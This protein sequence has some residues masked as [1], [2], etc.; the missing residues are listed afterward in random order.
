MN[1]Y[2][3]SF[4]TNTEFLGATVVEGINEK[5]AF[6]IATNNNLNPGGQAA[7]VEVPHELIEYH[8]SLMYKLSNKE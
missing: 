1:L 6:E 3:I 4:A 7:I 2:Y 5:Q 8:K